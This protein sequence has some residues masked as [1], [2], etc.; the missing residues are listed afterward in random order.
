MYEVHDKTLKYSR[1][2]FFILDS[3]SE[4]RLKLVWITESR[5]FEFFILLCILV[6]SISMAFYDY[7]GHHTGHNAKIDFMGEV[8]TWIFA[9][10]ALLKILA[11]GF[12]ISKYSYIR[13]WWNVID[14]MIV[15]FG[16]VDLLGVD[17]T[18]FKAMRTLRVL[19]PLKTIKSVP[20]MRVLV[21]ALISSL[22]DLF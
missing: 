12:F 13:D 3:H 17:A 5:L 7:T 6:N 10:E 16:L 9:V 14:F 20:S 2:S 22:P 11:Q 15:C 19:R 1:S 21:S 4:I 18:N 8:F